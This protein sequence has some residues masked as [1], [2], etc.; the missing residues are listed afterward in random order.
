MV[1]QEGMGHVMVAQANGC[2]RFECM[3]EK[4]GLT[5]HILAVT[6]MLLARPIPPME[7]EGTCIVGPGR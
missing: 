6:V 1:G 5:G 3:E 7:G 2:R 4:R